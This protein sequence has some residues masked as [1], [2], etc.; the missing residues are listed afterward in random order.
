[1]NSFKETFHGPNHLNSLFQINNLGAPL[2]AMKLFE[3]G[4]YPVWKIRK[5]RQRQA[6][7]HQGGCVG[8]YFGLEQLHDAG[9]R[10]SCSLKFR[11]WILLL[12]V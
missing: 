5:G 8:L 3:H 11:H 7:V 12:K 6:S 1:M 4:L 10:F 9:K 2:H